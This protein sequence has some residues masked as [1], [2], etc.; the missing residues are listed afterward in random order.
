MPSLPKGDLRRLPLDSTPVDF[1][2]DIHSKVGYHCIGAKINGRIVPLDTK[3]SSGD[4]IEIITSKNQQPNKNWLKFVKTHKAKANIRRWINAEEQK[5][6]DAGKEI[7]NKKIKKLKLSFSQD[8]ISKIASGSKY[9]NHRQFFI[10]IAQSKVNLDDVLV[11]KKEE[12]TTAA[13]STLEFDEFAQITRKDVGGILIDGKKTE[14][15]Y[16]YAK[17]C[18]PIPGDPI[19]GYITL[20]EGIKIHRKTCNN[21]LNLSDA[22][23][24]KL[25]PVQWPYSEESYFVAGLIVKGGR[26]TGHPK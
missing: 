15:L 18:N 4:Q 24:S 2:F 25:I 8:E 14:M 9:E 23:S 3:L 7:W 26:Q 10:A 22:D 12:D 5:I 1:A 21:L 6:V 16:S 13:E 11:P 17:C 19:I 20:G